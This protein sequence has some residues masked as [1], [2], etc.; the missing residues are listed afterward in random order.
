MS[1]DFAAPSPGTRPGCASTVFAASTSGCCEIRPRPDWA[2]R[3]AAD[4]S[5]GRAGT[6]PHCPTDGPA[7]VL[8]FGM[9][10]GPSGRVTVTRTTGSSSN[11]TTASSA[12]ETCAGSAASGSRGANRSSRESRAASAPTAR[13][14]ACRLRRPPGRP[15]A[16]DQV[17]PHGSDPRSRP[18][19]PDGGRGALAGMDRSAPSGRLARRRRAEHSLRSRPAG[20]PGVAPLRPRAWEEDVADRCAGTNRCG[21]PSLRRASR[22]R[23][24]R[25]PDDRLLSPRAGLSS[26][27]ANETSTRS[28]AFLEALDA[29][30]G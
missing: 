18:R 12:T 23:D 11:S 3:S 13:S 8:H 15:P 6:A 16:L 21:V 20:A 26:E 4:A 2:V 30:V 29:N 28:G 17:G 24:G 27:A 25:R 1:R 22:A 9:T 19:Q 5:G 10:G 7:L 14:L